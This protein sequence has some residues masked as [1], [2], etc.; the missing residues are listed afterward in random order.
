METLHDD[1]SATYQPRMKKAIEKLYPLLLKLPENMR[2]GLLQPV[3][4]LRRAMTL[5][6]RAAVLDARG[7]VLLVRHVYE[8]GWHL[9]GGGVEKGETVMDALRHELLDEAGIRITGTPCLF[10]I[11]SLHAVFPNDHV[12]LFVLRP[13]QYQERPWHPN[14]EIAERAFFAADDL[15]PDVTAGTRRRLKEV[16]TGAPGSEYW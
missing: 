16:L 6:V 2:R 5:G 13:G 15:P 7:R 10:G 12:A 9:P 1:L 3:L 14:A 11:Y 4:R 8:P